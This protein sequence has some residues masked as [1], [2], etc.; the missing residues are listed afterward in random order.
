MRHEANEANREVAVS[1]TRPELD[2][3][4]NR[5]IPPECVLPRGEMLI[6]LGEVRISS[7]VG[8]PL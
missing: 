3:R 2:S 4:R 7:A 8:Q 1:V 5:T 6:R